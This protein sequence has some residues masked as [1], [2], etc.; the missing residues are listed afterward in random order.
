MASGINKIHQ[1][2]TC[3]EAKAAHCSSTEECNQEL[4]LKMC[5]KI[6]Q[7]TKVIYALN[8][9]NDEHEASIQALKEAH[10]EEIQRIL[11]ETR[12]T[13]LQYKCKVG[14]EQELRKHIQ[15]L[16]DTLE[17]HTRLK[18]EALAEF[19]MC[20]KQVEEKAFRTEANH[21]ERI[22][23][24]SKEMLDTKTDFE[25]K[26]QH[27]NQESESLV[28]EC[29]PFRQEKLDKKETID[30]K[31]S[32]ELQALI[33]EMEN[34]KRENQKITEEYAQKA[35]KLQ[36]SYKKEK[37]TLKK[38]MQQSVAD[39]QKQCQQRATEQKKSS[40]AQEA[41]LRQQAKKLEA[42]LEVKGQKINELKKHSQKLKERMQDLEIQLKES[43]QETL[44]SK[45]TV[46]KLEEELTVAKERLM[47]QENEI[48]S[49]AEEMETV[50]NSQSK[51]EKEVDELKN[52]II[53]L[54]QMTC[55]KQSQT[56]EGSEATQPMEAAATE[57]ED[58]KQ[59]HKEELH[60]IKRQSDEEKMRLKEQLV[61]GLEDLVKKHT[62]E[63]KSAQTSMEAERKTLQKEVQ[64]QLE[65][66][67][68]NAE[69]EIKQLEK[70][71][72]ALSRKLQ[73][74]SLEVLRLEDF[75]RQNQDIPRYKEFLQ[76]HSRKNHERQQESDSPHCGTSEVQDPFLQ[77]KDRSKPQRERGKGQEPLRAQTGT[78]NEAKPRL[79]NARI[80]RREDRQPSLTSLQ[81]EKAKEAKVLQEE[82]H[83]QKMDLQA[84]V[85][86]L[87]QTL[88]QQANNFKESLKEQTLQSSKEK[89]KLLQDL[90]DTIQQSQTVKAQLEASHQ[91]ALQMLE[92]SKNQELKEA[93]EHLKKKYD[94]SIKIQH[95]SHRLEVQAL[96]EKAK[97]ELQGELE[98]IQKQQAA[99]IETLRMEL[100]EQYASCT[101][102]KK[103]MEELQME[104]KNV[105]ALK[106]QQ[107]GSN[108]NQITFLN[109]ELEKC[110]NEIAGLK[111]ENSLLKDTMEL[112]SPDLQK[113]KSTQLQDKE[114]Q[115]RLLEE[116]LKV[117]Y[118]KE[119]DILKQEHRKEI[120]NMIADFSSAQAHLQAKIVSLETELKEL[121]EKLRKRESR[122]EDMHLIGCLQNK[123]SEREEIIK[124]LTEG[125]KFQHLLLP[126][127]ESHRN[128]SFSFNPNPGCLT[129]SMK[130]KKLNEVPSRVVSVPNLASYAKN[131]LSCDLRS[132]RNAPPITKSTS[133]DQSAGCIRASYQSAQSSDSNH[134]TRTQG[135][136]APITKDD[137]KQDP[138]HQE[139]FTKYFSF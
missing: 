114:K 81:K 134:A 98:R 17:Q 71:K 5:K 120:Q 79:E 21:T 56:K 28:N 104:L 35:S 131:F 123:L 75:I 124:Q 84:Q 53:Q 90:Q 117:K 52:Q 66:L 106:K 125:R 29:K 127:T 67:R 96:E 8:T 20:K 6:A 76:S 118:Q 18:E 46:Q 74:S 41:A 80:P 48:L 62:M 45:S 112:L 116:D 15:T 23:T 69:N 55:T 36:A 68:K 139:W 10:Q 97:K 102:H 86:Q 16:E 51:A 130:Q 108:Q 138:R 132:K 44:E 93:E 4:H 85:V 12:E 82:W 57:I 22:I 113:Q 50:L 26:P 105:R 91:R 109:E 64:I 115:H 87:K 11:A 2:G 88:D 37:E 65:E 58:I 101:G 47:L 73:D 92:K 107:V 61:K 110:Q 122:P 83:N 133:L 9:K 33:N 63:I 128:R 39:T 19:T 32:I 99:L 60:K 38:A 7:L 78:R 42:E 31:R 13:I 77:Q 70:E 27:F 126:S 129:P 14:E 1:P 25:N 95:Q 24:L 136:E 49:K 54:Q 30:E 137:Q 59:R 72:E 135:N 89:E 3:N 40:E 43:Q 111:K 103:Q 100:S 119:L 94:D 34:L 121:E